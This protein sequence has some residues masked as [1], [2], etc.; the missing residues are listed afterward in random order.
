MIK[1]IPCR[2]FGHKY[3]PITKISEVFQQDCIRCGFKSKIDPITLG[4][5]SHKVYETL[6]ET[7]KMR[8]VFHDNLFNFI[9]WGQFEA[10]PWENE[11]KTAKS[12]KDY[13]WQNRKKLLQKHRERYRKKYKL[14]KEEKI[15]EKNHISD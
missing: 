13:Y 8:Q 7:I 1:K 15:N 3:K 14:K 6:M 10:I 5:G 2:I 11:E 9:K 12:K 4:F